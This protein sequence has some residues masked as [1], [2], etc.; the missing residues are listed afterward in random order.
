MLKEKQPKCVSPDPLYSVT[1]VHHLT[2]NHCCLSS[3]GNVDWEEHENMSSGEKV[4]KK[5]TNE[6]GCE[7][8][9]LLKL[10]P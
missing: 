5:Q 10:L 2:H 4:K 9:E 8:K 6:I 1:S 3:P 7:S